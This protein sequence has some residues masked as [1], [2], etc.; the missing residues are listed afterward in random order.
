MQNA[1]TR[2]ERNEKEMGMIGEKCVSILP[3]GEEVRSK[4]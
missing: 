3:I 1:G 2:K 4:A